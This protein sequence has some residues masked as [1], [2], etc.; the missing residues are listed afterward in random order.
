MNNLA[1]T[2]D[3]FDALLDA[4]RLGAPHVLAVTGDI[5]AAARRRMALAARRQ[6][7]T[8]DDTASRKETPQHDKTGHVIAAGFDPLS[9]TQDTAAVDLPVLDAGSSRAVSRTMVPVQRS[10][11]GDSALAT[12][13]DRS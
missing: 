5:P 12:S 8:L 9:T 3:D 4:S 13:G 10:T 7:R 1:G 11:V 2:D 6:Q